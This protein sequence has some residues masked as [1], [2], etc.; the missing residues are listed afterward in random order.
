MKYV[1]DDGYIEGGFTKLKLVIVATC[2]VIEKGFTNREEEETIIDPNPPTPSGKVPTIVGDGFDIDESL[3]VPIKRDEGGNLIGITVV[4]NIE[5]EN[6][7]SNLKVKI[8]SETLTPELLE[9]VGLASEFDLAYPGDLRTGLESLG[10]PVGD[11]V[12]GKTTLKFDI[13]KFTPL[14]GSYGPATHKFII[15]A[16]DQS[17]NSVEKTLT[18]ISVAEGE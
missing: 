8:D 6:G 9:E 15:T 11:Q 13:T 4:V 18:L 7:F 12:L 14:L 5:A 2:T 16:I 3:D 10:F 1:N 17:G